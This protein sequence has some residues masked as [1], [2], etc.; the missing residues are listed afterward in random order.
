MS[1]KESS[2]QDVFTSLE[3]EEIS[4][5]SLESTDDETY[6]PDQEYSVDRILAQKSEDGQQLYLLRWTGFPEEVC[7]W[8]PRKNILAKSIFDAWRVRKSRESQGLDTPYDIGQL[9]A[10]K[11]AAHDTKV[12]RH[13]L[14]REKRRR[15]GI[16][17]SPH[18]SDADV[19]ETQL[20]ISRASKNSAPLDSGERKFERR[21][22][23]QA[24][25]T[26]K[27]HIY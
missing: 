20:N 5:L 8:E 11:K 15:Q 6:S 7:S 10:Q 24:G 3:E 19:G 21:Q 25:K 16:V 13:R 2:R 1:F 9:E 14:R 23:V 4:K 22:N 12:Q 27:V 26:A 17:V 18:E